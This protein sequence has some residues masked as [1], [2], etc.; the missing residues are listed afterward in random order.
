MGDF[1]HSHSVVC[2]HSTQCTLW[3]ILNWK[4]LFFFV[5]KEEVT[6]P[7]LCLVK[8]TERLSWQEAFMLFQIYFQE[9]SSVSLYPTGRLM[10]RPQRA[11]FMLS[12][13]GILQTVGVTLY[14][15]HSLPLFCFQFITA[16]IG[17]PL[18]S[19]YVL[20]GSAEGVWHLCSTLNHFSPLGNVFSTRISC[21]KKLHSGT[22]SASHEHECDAR[23]LDAGVR[24]ISIELGRW[25]CPIFTSKQ[26]NKDHSYQS[27]GRSKPAHCEGD[28]HL[29]CNDRAREPSRLW[30]RLKQKSIPVWLRWSRLRGEG[31][32]KAICLLLYRDTV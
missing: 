9:S 26:P 4:S 23:S 25:L 32:E 28:C 1:R 6:R 20:Y 10:I 12:M 24:R 31:L 17:L 27:R 3:H 15:T 30:W 16:P 11:R 22:A 7:Y 18:P 13:W 5:Y 14:L 29:T 21:N 8:I 19:I 2:T